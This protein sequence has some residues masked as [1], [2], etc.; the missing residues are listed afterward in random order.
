MKNKKKIKIDKDMGINALI[1]AYPVVVDILQE[2]YEFH[3]VNCM[4][5]E[6]DTLENGAI[7]HGIEGEDF[8]D[9]VEHL[10]KVINK[11]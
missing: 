1:E 5:S 7:L 6:F 10:E 2:E 3:C 9:M 4:F 8:N 11:E